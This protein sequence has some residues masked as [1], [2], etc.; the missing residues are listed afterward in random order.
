MNMRNEDTLFA[1]YAFNAGLLV[2][3]MFILAF[4]TGL[5]RTLRKVTPN[6]EDAR[7][8]GVEP[9]NKT[10]PNVERVKRAH[11]NDLENIPIFLIVSFVYIHTQPNLGLCHFLF[12]TFTAARFGHSIIY[13]L[14]PLPQPT[15]TIIFL[16]GVAITIFM[17]FA[18]FVYFINALVQM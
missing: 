10:D 13:A 6:A 3:K 2:L 12:W 11:L 7:A 16:V 9:S 8:M 1:I 4:S 15:R 5:V 18:N 17:I 14:Y